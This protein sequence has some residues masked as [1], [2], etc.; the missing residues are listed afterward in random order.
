MRGNVEHGLLSEPPKPVASV[1]IPVEQDPDNSPWFRVCMLGEEVYE[2]N[3]NGTCDPGNSSLTSES[4]QTIEI[5]ATAAEQKAKQML[6]KRTAGTQ[7]YSQPTVRL[8]TGTE[9]GR[10]CKAFESEAVALCGNGLYQEGHNN[11]TKHYQTAPHDQN[12]YNFVKVQCG[13]KTFEV[14]CGCKDALFETRVGLYMPPEYTPY[15]FNQHIKWSW[16]LKKSFVSFVS[17]MFGCAEHAAKKCYDKVGGATPC[18]TDY[19]QPCVIQDT[20]KP[21]D[22]SG[23]APPKNGTI[24][25]CGNSKWLRSGSKCSLQCDMGFV[26]TEPL[27]CSRGKLT[28]TSR[29]VCSPGCDFDSPEGKAMFAP[30]PPPPTP[31]NPPGYL[32][33]PPPPMHEWYHP[34]KC[35]GLLKAGECSSPLLH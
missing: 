11:A 33:T 6:D 27:A 3:I 15:C 4:S 8:R 23:V 24:G 10:E 16:E 1:T 20:E 7:W 12:D 35:V 29:V 14:G 18:C 13:G 32:L 2:K 5:N 21:C 22:V 31:D 28:N 26:Q 17:S 34:G 25:E 9:N 30:P 19:S